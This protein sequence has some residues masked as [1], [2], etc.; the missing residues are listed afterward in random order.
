M[1]QEV[2]LSD[3]QY[4]LVQALGNLGRGSAREVQH[5]VMHLGLA[6]TTVA[7]V[8]SRLETKGVL[9]SEVRGR[10]R[11][12]RCLVDEKSIRQSMVSSLVSTL[13]KGDSKALMAHLVE[14]GEINPEKL[15]ELHALIK[16]ER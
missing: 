2:K 13:F 16:K 3:Q 10:E 6:H 4:Q 5:E 9:A 12:Y 14:E 1:A 11:V 8:L 15:D 7:T